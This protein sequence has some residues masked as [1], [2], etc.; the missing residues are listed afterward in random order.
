MIPS[1]VTVYNRQKDLAFS[2]KRCK[3]HLL[4]LLSYLNI[5]TDEL[6]LHFVTEKKISDLHRHFFDDPS[7]TD[8][9][10][11][12][13]DAASSQ[14]SGYHVLGEIFVCPK[15]AMR[16][17]K[18]HALKVQEELM[19]YVIHGLLHLIGYDDMTLKERRVM[20]KKEEECLQWLF[21]KKFKD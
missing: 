20:K 6:I 4:L 3:K 17:A 16:Y 21:S 5:T 13:I 11:I 1:K 8:C 14:G 15:V 10:S 19:R 2:L 12:P 9:I 7:S 18:Q